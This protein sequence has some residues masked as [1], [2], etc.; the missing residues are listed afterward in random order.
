V[1]RFTNSHH[2]NCTCTSL[3][4]AWYRDRSKLTKTQTRCMPT[5][6]HHQPSSHMIHRCPHDMIVEMSALGRSHSWSWW[7]HQEPLGHSHSDR[8]HT[9]AC[10]AYLLAG[11]D[12]VN[13]TNTPNASRRSG[14][15]K[16][17]T[18]QH[19]ADQVVQ[20][21]CLPI[22]FQCSTILQWPPNESTTK[23]IHCYGPWH[24]CVPVCRPCQNYLTNFFVVITAN[25]TDSTTSFWLT[26]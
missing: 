11:L 19:K 1:N 17:I 6:W 16:D 8:C 14:K 5:Y 4:H 12:S 22:L 7:E 3:N 20:T 26:V 21:F 23:Y 25:E 18:L 10:E 13:V 2:K 9:T 24:Q 15:C